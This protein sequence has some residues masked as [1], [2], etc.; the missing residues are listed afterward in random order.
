MSEM[1]F[2]ENF[3]DLPVKAGTNAGFPFEFHCPPAANSARNAARRP[4]RR[5]D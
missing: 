5:A 3:Q 1:N 4:V 2:S